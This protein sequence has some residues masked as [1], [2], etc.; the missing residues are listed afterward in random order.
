MKK[1][2][3]FLNEAGKDAIAE[4]L[5]F[6]HKDG[7]KYGVHFENFDASP[8]PV[9]TRILDNVDKVVEPST[10]TVRGR[11]DLEDTSVFY[12][13]EVNGYVDEEGEFQIEYIKGI[14]HEFDSKTKDVYCLYMT[15]WIQIIIDD[16]G[17][18]KILS[19]TEFEG[20][21]PEGGAIRP[22]GS[23]RP[24]VAIA[25]YHDSSD[26]NGVPNSVSGAA[27][28]YNCS[29][30]SLLTK[31]RKKG[32]QYCATSFQD[33]ERMNN[34]MDVAFATRDSQS[35]MYGAYNYYLQYAA[36]V[37]EDD[38]ERIIIS[39][40][41]AAKF[42]VGSCV[43]IGNATILSSGKPNIDRG[44]V[45]MHAKA[46]RVVIT[47][48]EEY[49]ANNSAIYVDNGGHVFSTKPD[50]VSDVECPT[51]ISTMPWHTGSTDCVLGSCGSP[52]DNKNGK[53]P[54]V[55]FGVEYALGQYE[56]CGNARM[57]ITDGVMKP[58]FC[59]DSTK[60]SSVKKD[61]NYVTTDYEVA[62][63]GTSWKYIS[64]LGYDPEHPMARYG[65]EVNA[66]SSTGY[67][68]AQYTG[69]VSETT[70]DQREILL[71]GTLGSGVACG[72]RYAGLSNGLTYSYWFYAA[73]LSASGVCGSEAA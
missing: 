11:N 50:T 17:E 34:L 62:I 46:D 10:D 44:Q 68:D 60:L 48:I 18:T 64:V 69:N 66:T 15:Q 2:Y 51:Y 4:M 58:Y 55:L 70:N 53:N 40:T 27:P 59:Y 41:D 54:Y 16:T 49:D 42:L 14:D 35:V 13:I 33:W 71:G 23:V 8:S 67:A 52:N 20:S 26:T 6:E 32:T 22:D 25:K 5:L 38:V 56:V 12:H 65:I 61:P 9:G 57:D 21:Y 45:G 73:R 19:D 30:N 37:T 1:K 24:F 47:K 29:H 36:T 31:M 39:K 28:S 3:A 43:S 7:K 63:T 72:R